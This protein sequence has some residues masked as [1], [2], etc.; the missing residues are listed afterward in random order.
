MILIT[1]A[2][3]FIG[4]LLV[5]EIKR[6]FPKQKIYCLIFKSSKKHE[7][8]GL[9]I[10]KKSNVIIQP[11]DLLNKK[12]LVKIPKNPKVIIHLAASVDT[13]SSNFQTNDIGTQNLYD[14]LGSL[15]L[16]TKF[17]F[18]STAAVWAGRK[19]FSKPITESEKPDPNN[20]YGRTKLKAENFLTCKSKQDGFSL[21]I[22]RLNTVYGADSRRD[23]LFGVITGYISKG[24]VLGRINWPGKF[25]IIHVKDVVKIIIA[26]CK[27]RTKISDSVSL[28]LVSTENKS[29]QQISLLIHQEMGFKYRPIKIPEFVWFVVKK[30]MSLLPLLEILLPAYLY[31]Y[32]WRL[33]LAVND[34]LLGRPI[35]INKRFPDLRKIEFTNS[36]KEVVNI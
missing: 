19:S 10:L 26:V 1:G 12:S 11:I 22:L 5:P 14:A 8:E 34:V 32:F 9:E 16:R 7:K 29:L 28:Y 13:S 21:T 30:T 17:I 23:K 36:I 3:G 2:N 31:N 6:A 4:Q 20:Q 25:G 18:I 27:Q 33:N 15:D 35:K 24:S